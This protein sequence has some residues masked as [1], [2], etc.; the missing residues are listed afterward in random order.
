MAYTIHKFQSGAGLPMN[1][2]MIDSGQTRSQVLRAVER[3]NLPEFTC[4][5]PRFGRM[6][7]VAS[8]IPGKSYC[9]VHA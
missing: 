6:V 5:L 7:I 2:E 1:G 8:A 3:H 4:P 9:V